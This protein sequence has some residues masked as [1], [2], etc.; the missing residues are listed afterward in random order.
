MS[1]WSGGYVTEVDY[2]YGFYREMSPAMMRFALLAA[3]F[4][5][6]PLEQFAYCELGFGQGHGLN[7]LAAANAQGDFWGT[8]F[9]PQHA[10]GAR[11]L[12]H[13]AGL[14]NLHVFDDS[15]EQFAS[16]D[17]PSFDYI[18][19]HGV[20]S[21]VGAENRRHIVDFIN[22]HL[23]LGGAVYASYNTLPGWAG[24][25]PIR[26]LLYRHVYSQVAE[27]LPLRERTTQALEFLKQ[28]SALPT[29]YLA[30]GGQPMKEQVNRL[31]QQD[32]S[33]LAHEYLNR[34][35]DPM[36]FADVVGELEG[37]KLTFAGSA[38]VAS[39]V[40][41]LQM[42]P[43]IQKLFASVADPMHRET[44]RDFI[45]NQRFRR[46]I[47]VRGPR[48][49]PAGVQSRLLLGTPIALVRARSEC[50]LEVQMGT[51]NVTLKP[52]IYNPVLDALASQPMTG[53][54]LNQMPAIRELGLPRLFQALMVLVGAGYAQPCTLPSL[55]GQSTE[56]VKRF[57]QL[58][59]AHTTAMYPTLNNLAS[60]LLGSGFGVGRV[61]KMCLD[62]FLQGKG[63]DANAWTKYAWDA[64]KGA[65]QVMM[66]DNKRVEGD[67]ANL[68]ELRPQ[69]EQLI[70]AAPM[71]KAL[72]VVDL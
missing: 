26:E 17:L 42:S 4:E 62:A 10:A 34:H 65:G 40:D 13:A 5:A 22:R 32:P 51:V 30:Q 25:L 9:N 28:V 3:G 41:M 8:D 58:I 43:E 64:I 63:V 68:A 6:P 2:T 57:N 60:P 72:Q 35:W 70:A 55:V 61:P 33:Y 49:L 1:E 7:L 46:D 48:P 21:W 54:Q 12:A 20:Y 27:G 11:N 56:S 69:V 31:M 29:G 38:D 23:K 59:C 52:E 36:Y 16:R 53:D 45:V 37:A 14:A 18:A 39:R 71:L 66:K 44:V 47:F 50:K 19:L 15:F 67:E 24:F